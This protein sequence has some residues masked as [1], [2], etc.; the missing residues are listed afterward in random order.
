MVYAWLDLV[1]DRHRESWSWVETIGF[2]MASAGGR[3]DTK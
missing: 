2:D 3:T 1:F